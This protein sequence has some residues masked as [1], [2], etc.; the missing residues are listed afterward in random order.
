VIGAIGTNPTIQYVVNLPA[1]A[2]SLSNVS[3]LIHGHFNQLYV[4]MVG[5][6]LIMNQMSNSAN[7]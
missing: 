5:M 6:P 2:T 3:T 7:Y 4:E 1:T